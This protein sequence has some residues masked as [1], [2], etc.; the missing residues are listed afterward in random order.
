MERKKR[1]KELQNAILSLET[2]SWDHFS[3]RWNIV[4]LV[5]IWY[6]F[7]LKD[8][9]WIFS[10]TR[11]MGDG[12]W[13]MGD[14]WQMT[15]VGRNVHGW[16]ELTGTYLTWIFS[17]TWVMGD[18]SW[19]ERTRVTGVEQMIKYFKH[20]D[21]NVATPTSNILKQMRAP[22]ASIIVSQLPWPQLKNH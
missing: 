14:G 8:L 5:Q 11:V 18:R 12:R 1:N 3:R 17:P 15:G 4:I 22:C 16:Q 21:A 20:R 6:Y 10:S 7:Q 19:Q 9:T 2:N 13:A